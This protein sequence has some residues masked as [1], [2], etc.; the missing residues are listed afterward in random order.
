MEQVEAGGE[1]AVEEARLGE[2]QVDLQAL[3]RAG[4]PQAQELAVAQQVALGDADVADDALARRVAGAERELTRGLLDQLDIEDDAVRRRAGAA[5]DLDGLEEAERLQA[6]LGL[7]DQQRIV[8]VALG[9]PE[10][11]PDHVVLRAQVADDVDALDVDARTFVD[12]VGDVICA[13]RV[14]HRARADAREGEALLGDGEGQLL[15]R[16][17]DADWS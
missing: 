17:V 8:G 15:D 12:H 9:Q 1:V 6:L 4:Q 14:A 13:T 16:V 3:E 11:A 2:A 10:L 7:V 5:F